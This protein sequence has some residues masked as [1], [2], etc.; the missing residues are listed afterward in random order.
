MFKATYI[1][2]KKLKNP[3]PIKIS[4]QM[5]IPVWTMFN[6]AWILLYWIY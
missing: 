2:Q 4:K 5:F 3:Q 1:F 6:N